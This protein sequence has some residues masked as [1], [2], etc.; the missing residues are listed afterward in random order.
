MGL[1]LDLDDQGA[2]FRGEGFIQLDNAVTVNIGFRV[3]VKTGFN[4]IGPTQNQAVAQY[5]RTVAAVIACLE[6]D[7]PENGSHTD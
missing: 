7:R 5:G 6:C 2:G 3:L 4:G 1:P